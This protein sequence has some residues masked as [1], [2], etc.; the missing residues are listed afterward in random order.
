MKS[1]TQRLKNVPCLLVLVEQVKASRPRRIR[2]LA[3]ALSCRI[4]VA[5]RMRRGLTP[6][7]V[8]C[9]VDDSPR[10]EKQSLTALVGME[11]E[12]GYDLIDCPAVSF[13]STSVKL[14]D[15]TSS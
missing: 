4:A 9:R 1:T 7:L 2:I 11:S 6:T 15:L 14:A 12:D 8:R 5:L 13:Q 3:S 10:K